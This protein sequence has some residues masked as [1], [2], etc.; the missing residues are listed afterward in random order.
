MVNV[1]EYAQARADK[2]NTPYLITLFGHCW[3]DCLENRALALDPDIGQ[4][5]DK[6][7]YPTRKLLKGIK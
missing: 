4:G 6:I 2:Q 5:I 3:L 1:Q 7:I